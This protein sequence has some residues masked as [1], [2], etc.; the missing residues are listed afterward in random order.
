VRIHLL[1]PM[2]ATTY[3]GDNVLPHGKRAR[4]VLGYLCLHG[5]GHVPRARLAALLWD[6]VSEAAART[7]LRQALREL[8]S[9]FGGLA[10]EAIIS[11]RDVVRLNVGACWVDA[12][13]ALALDPLAPDAPHVDL[14]AL[15]RG[16]LLKTS[17]A[18]VRRSTAG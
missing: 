18:P 1:G 11:G 6:R 5:G 7:N 8:S 14:T 13:A 4:A 10:K 2:R 16:E 17:T 9:T 15:C 3:L 12:L